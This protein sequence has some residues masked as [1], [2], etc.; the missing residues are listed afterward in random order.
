[1][2]PLPE[3]ESGAAPLP[4]LAGASIEVTPR[5]L[6]RLGGEGLR[7]QRGTEV[8]VAHIDGAGFAEL[9]AAARQL[10]ELGLEPVPHVPAR[11][12]PDAAELG[13]RRQAW[14][15]EAGVRRALLIG[16]G[17]GQPLG[18]LSSS[19]DLVE[20][21]H[22]DRLGFGHLYFAG[23]P[24]GSRDLDPDGGTRQADAALEWKQALARRS[25][26]RLE[27]VTQFLFDAAPAIAW[28]ARIS[29]AGIGLPVRIGLAGPAR[30][31]S[32]IRFG[33]ECGVGPSL[34]VLQR[35]ARDIR[36]L[37][38]PVTPDAVVADLEAHRRARPGTT[39][40]GLHLFPLGRV[41][42]CIDWLEKARIGA[43]QKAGPLSGQ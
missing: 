14:R 36:K 17:R 2:R 43:A 32:L 6:A 21:G 42:G 30:L 20:T 7:L 28:A 40:T 5:T 16:G 12:I 1:M 25:D 11:L 29:A 37:L 34:G 15:D 8:F 39:I 22:F 38:L 19:L 27:L 23:H 3:R 9:L 4:M 10:R 33:L 41:E 13:R 24:E 35:R 31:Q 26:A 18:S